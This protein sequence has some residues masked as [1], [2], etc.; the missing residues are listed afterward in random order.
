[1]N[2]ETISLKEIKIE[3]VYNYIN[4]SKDTCDEQ[5]TDLFY[6]PNKCNINDIKDAMGNIIFP[7]YKDLEGYL[8]FID[9]IN[10]ANWSHTCCYVFL[11]EN[12]DIISNNNADWFPS[13]S[14]D[15]IKINVK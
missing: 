7:K 13:S 11:S 6:C 3:K 15:I 1:M 4:D 8:I 10:I 2:I 12:G 5:Y 9:P 14:I